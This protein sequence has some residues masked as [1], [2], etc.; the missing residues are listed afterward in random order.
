MT[1]PARELIRRTC[2]E[3]ASSPQRELSS[4]GSDSRSGGTCS[5]PVA[6]EGVLT[7]SGVIVEPAEGTSFYVKVCTLCWSTTTTHK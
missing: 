6:P 1:D 7:W 2:P 3:A 5:M 4:N